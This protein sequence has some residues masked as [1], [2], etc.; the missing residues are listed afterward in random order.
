MEL[1]ALLLSA[2]LLQKMP[3]PVAPHRPH[4]YAVAMVAF[5]QHPAD[6]HHYRDF[7]TSVGDNS[8]D[9]SGGAGASISPTLAIEG[10]LVY[11]GIVSTPQSTFYTEQVRDIL[12]NALVRYRAAAMPR[13]SLV[14]GGGYAWTRTSEEP[15]QGS[16]PAIWWKGATLTGGADVAVVDS[17]HVALAPAFRVRWVKRADAL[18]GWNGLGAFSFQIGA[19]VILR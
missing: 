18:D 3:P 15:V 8:F 2:A 10:E 19:T 1:G 14:A 12:L 9:L 6:A 13:V 17:A 7:I 5:S 16:R 4:A 11:G